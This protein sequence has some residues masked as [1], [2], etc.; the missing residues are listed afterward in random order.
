MVAPHSIIARDEEPTGGRDNRPAALWAA[1]IELA[2][3]DAF[4]RKIE[5]GES[6]S[7][8]HRRDRLA[9]FERD[10]REALRFLTDTRGPWARSRDLVCSMAGICPDAL[11]EAAVAKGRPPDG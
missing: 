11:R 10:R 2:W 4:E 9:E 8:R 5:I 1:V 3:L 7:E 6:V